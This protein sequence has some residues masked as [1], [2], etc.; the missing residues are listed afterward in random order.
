MR[1]KIKQIILN[2]NKDSFCKNCIKQQID[3][4]YKKEFSIINN[5]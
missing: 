1:N 3:C 4:F 5:K 2:F